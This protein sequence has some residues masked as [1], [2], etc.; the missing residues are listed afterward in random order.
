MNKAS[1]VFWEFFFLLFLDSSKFFLRLE[2]LPATKTLQ[3]EAYITW[4]II[5][6][7]EMRKNQESC[8]EEKWRKDVMKAK[9]KM[10]FHFSEDNDKVKVEKRDV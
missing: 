9:E 6:L 5:V 10:E 8:G 3:S 2:Q 4:S 1:R 7:K